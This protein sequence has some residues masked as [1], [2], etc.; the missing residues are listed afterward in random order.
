MIFEE[1]QPPNFGAQ[2]SRP[3]VVDWNRDGVNDIV[4]VMQCHEGS[5]ETND[6]TVTF[7]IFVKS[8]HSDESNKRNPQTT[9]TFFGEGDTLKKG[10]YWKFDKFRFSEIDPMTQNERNKYSRDRIVKV[11]FSFADYDQ[12]GN[13]DALF[14]ESIYK[15]CHVKFDKRNTWCDLKISSSIYLMRNLSSSGEPKFDRPIRIFDAPDN[16]L[17]NSITAGQLDDEAGLE[18]IAGVHFTNPNDPHVTNSE[19]WL[20]RQK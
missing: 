3:Y 12:D 4:V 8:K 10:R 9:P 20:L 18:V 2:E 14:S 16:W 11:H 6:H 7:Q 5:I 15:R 1:R 17:I 13:F 19:L